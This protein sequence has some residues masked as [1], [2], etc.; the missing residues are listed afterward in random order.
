MTTLE[1]LLADAAP[2]VRDALG[3]VGRLSEEALRAR[4]DEYDRLAAFPKSSFEALFSAGLLGATIPVDAG[5][6][7]FGHHRGNTFPLWMMTKL[8]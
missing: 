6:L 8:I 7:G 1:I 4:A 3:K 2:G 5:G